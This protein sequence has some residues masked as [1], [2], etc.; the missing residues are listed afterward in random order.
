MSSLS[1][2]VPLLH[3]ASLPPSASIPMSDTPPLNL[4]SR[5]LAHTSSLFPRAAHTSPIGICTCPG[6]PLNYS[7]VCYRSPTPDCFHRCCSKCCIARGGWSFLGCKHPDHRV[8]VNS[9]GYYKPNFHFPYVTR[10]RPWILPIVSPLTGDLT[11][12][13]GAAYRDLITDGWEDGQKLLKEQAESR[14]TSGEGTTVFIVLWTEVSMF[15]AH[16]I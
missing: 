13:A 9:A 16:I 5:I 11:R 1:Q 14:Y 7:I 4:A 12:P 3:Q 2:D 6:P 15:A 8:Y 10:S